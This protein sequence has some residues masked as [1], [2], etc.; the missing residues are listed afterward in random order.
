[1]SAS[2][3]HNCRMVVLQTLFAVSF[4]KKKWQD[5]LK[6]IAKEVSYYEVDMK[7]CEQLLEDIYENL[8]EIHKKITK[9]APQWPLEK[10]APMDRNI[11]ELGVCEL[12]YNPETPAL[13]AIN[14]AIELSK[15]FGSDNS[16]KFINAVLSTIY[17]KSK[18]KRK[19]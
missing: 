8:S 7:F 9:Y 18:K 12:L 15:E 17:E 4:G 2:S 3:R 19:S 10:I 13:V 1:M 5:V 6:Y 14:E 11:L 16:S